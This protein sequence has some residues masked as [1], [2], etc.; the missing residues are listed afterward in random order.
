MPLEEVDRLA[1]AAAELEVAG[2]LGQGEDVLERLAEDLDEAVRAY[3]IARNFDLL[4]EL[5]EYGL[6]LTYLEPPA[7][8]A[9]I[10]FPTPELRDRAAAAPPAPGG[11]GSVLVRPIRRRLL[12]PT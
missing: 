10:W 9:T 2:V 4:A 12:V 5:E 6:E 11:G 3:A 7:G 1:A 8:V